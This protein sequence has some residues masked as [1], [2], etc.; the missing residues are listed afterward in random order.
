MTII[1]I[2]SGTE[3]FTCHWTFNIFLQDSR[4]AVNA[5]RSK[6]TRKCVTFNVSTI[7]SITPGTLCK[8]ILARFKFRERCSKIIVKRYV[9]R[10]K[11]KNYTSK[12]P[13]SEY[14]MDHPPEETVLGNLGPLSVDT[15]PIDL[16][17][18]GID[19]DLIESEPA[20]P[21]PEITA[22]PEEGH[23]EDGK[24]RLEETF[25]GTDAGS[26]G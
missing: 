25:S 5:T 12:V 20:G 1:L 26:N 10:E 4:R 11:G 23:N 14:N 24:I 2:N 18:A 22:D 3:Y 6:F 17:T 16:T 7:Y 15:H 8:R 13:S 19:I 9:T 21:L